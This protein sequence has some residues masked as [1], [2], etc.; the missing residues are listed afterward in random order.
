MRKPR[1]DKSAED[2]NCGDGTGVDK[3]ESH[4]GDRLVFKAYR[5]KGLA[6]YPDRHGRQRVSVKR[7]LVGAE[8]A[9]GA[10]E[11]RGNKEWRQIAQIEV[12]QYKPVKKERIA[13]A[14]AEHRRQRNE[15]E[16]YEPPSSV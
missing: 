3:T 16:R 7:L 1:A 8:I 5:G 6:D 13:P 2:I 9:N 10:A 4:L 14:E 11:R 12:E 15:H